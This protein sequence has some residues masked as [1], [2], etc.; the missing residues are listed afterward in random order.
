MSYITL[1]QLRSGLTA[2]KNYTDT[3]TGNKVDKITGK[4]LSTEDYTTEEKSKLGGLQE[5]KSI[6]TGLN[7]N[8]SGELI[9]TGDVEASSVAWTNVTGKPD[10]FYDDT[11]LAT[12]VAANES[13]ITVL[14]GSGAGSVSKAVSDAIDAVVDGAPATFDTL[15]ELADWI[16][17]DQTGAAAIAADLANKADTADIP[18]AEADANITT[19]IA[20]VFGSGS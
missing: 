19:M 6:G 5:I 2:S 16:S 18:E 20:D 3:Q 1:S 14:N 12:R 11:A 15:K 4:G 9:A 17:D 7:L 10:T 8:S 13:A